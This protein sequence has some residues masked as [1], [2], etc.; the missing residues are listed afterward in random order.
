MDR[1]QWIVFSAVIGALLAA[2][3]GLIFIQFGDTIGTALA[4]PFS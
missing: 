1:V 3:L 4:S 2:Y